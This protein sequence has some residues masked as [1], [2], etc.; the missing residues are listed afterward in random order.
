MIVYC[1]SN[2]PSNV[3]AIA[4]H[5]EIMMLVLFNDAF[6]I[7]TNLFAFYLYIWKLH[8]RL[9]R[10][11]SLRL[12]RGS[13]LYVTKRLPDEFKDHLFRRLKLSTNRQY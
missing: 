13:F 2:D 7:S 9:Q 10:R 4:F 5:P 8:P 11:R 6:I 3:V 12:P 1:R